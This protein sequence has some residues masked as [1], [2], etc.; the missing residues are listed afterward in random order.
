MLRSW[1]H[2]SLRAASRVHTQNPVASLIHVES[3]DPSDAE[4]A[5][6]GGS[7]LVQ[8][9]SQYLHEQQPVQQTHDTGIAPLAV[10][11]AV[12]SAM[13]SWPYRATHIKSEHLRQHLK[14]QGQGW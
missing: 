2:I 6:V 10:V 14:E 11:H 5:G 1:Q 9:L 4:T 13:T 8:H 3:A 7:D 12:T